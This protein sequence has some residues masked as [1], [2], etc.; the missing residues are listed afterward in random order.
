MGAVTTFQDSNRRHHQ[1]NYTVLTVTHLTSLE[2]NAQEEVGSNI[3]ELTLQ[4]TT[5]LQQCKGAGMH[6]YWGEMALHCHVD[7]QYQCRT[8]EQV[9]H[10]KQQARSSPHVCEQKRLN[11]K[12]GGGRGRGGGG[13][14]GGEAGRYLSGL[15]RESCRQASKLRAAARCTRTLPQSASHNTMLHALD[16]Q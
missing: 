5:T 3:I 10:T 14:G 2:E 9:L 4:P 16:H 7:V 12:G 13:L 11:R 6:R 8:A 15:M 1:Y